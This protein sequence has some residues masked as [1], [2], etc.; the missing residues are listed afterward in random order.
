MKF[1]NFKGNEKIKE[2]LSFLAEA[3]RLPHAIIL[4]GEAGLGKRT[5]AREIALNLFCRGEGEKPC[6]KCA[7][8]SKVTKGIHPDIYE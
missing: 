1:I 7:Q 2:Q 3:K 6:L 4:E 5:L 8:C